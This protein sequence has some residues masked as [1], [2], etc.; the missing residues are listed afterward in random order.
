MRKTR[1]LLIFTLLAV[2]TDYA[3]GLGCS[4][5][6]ISVCQNE[7]QVMYFGGKDFYRLSTDEC[8]QFVDCTGL[9]NGQHTYLIDNNI[10]KCVSKIDSSLYSPAANVSSNN[11]TDEECG[12]NSELN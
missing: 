4:Q 12:V 10:N 3:Q 6:N 1:F 11:Q 7:C 5:A 2:C 8:E 9:Q